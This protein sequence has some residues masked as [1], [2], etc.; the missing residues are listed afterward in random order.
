MTGNAR[1]YVLVL[2][3]TVTAA[4]DSLGPPTDDS[5]R[6]PVVQVNELVA[7]ELEGVGDTH[8]YVLRGGSGKARVRLD[9]HVGAGGAPVMVEVLDSASSVLIASNAPGPMAAPAETGWF[10]LSSMK[11]YL[12][13]VYAAASNGALAYGFRV[14]PLE[15]RVTIGDTVYGEMLP[16]SNVTFDSYA[17]AG[18]TGLEVVIFL[19]ATSGQD[20]QYTE[21]FVR[22]PT[23]DVNEWIGSTS[24]SGADSVLEASSTGRMILPDD[25][26][27]QIEIWGGGH[28]SAS[29]HGVGPYRF[30][31]Y[32]VDR[33][34]ETAPSRIEI[35][36]TIT[37]AIDAVADIDEFVFHGEAGTIVNVFFQI[38]TGLTGG[39]W[40]RLLGIGEPFQE[41][42]AHER[43]PALEDYRTGRVVLPTTGDHRVRI[44]GRDR[45][46]PR[47]DTGFYRFEVSLVDP[48]PESV[49]TE[50]AIGQRVD[51]ERLDRPG[52]IDEFVVSAAPGTEVIVLFE[53]EGLPDEH[54]LVLT[55]L[56][57]DSVIWTTL[58]G[59]PAEYDVRFAF[60]TPDP[61]A[62]RVNS[63]DPASGH[64]GRYSLQ[65]FP[66]DRAPESISPQIEVGTVVTGETIDPRGEV[67]EFTFQGLA[68]QEVMIF[69]R[70]LPGFEGGLL[71]NL[72]GSPRYLSVW[73]ECDEVI[74]CHTGNLL[75][76]LPYDGT[77]TIIVDADPGASHVGSGPYEFLVF[78]IDRAP[79]HVSPALVIGDTVR[80]EPIFPR[81]DIDEFHF[82]GMAGDELGIY[83]TG[84]T[85]NLSLTVWSL[86]TGDTVA[87]VSPDRDEQEWGNFDLPATGP[88]LVRVAA[89]GTPEEGECEFIYR[90]D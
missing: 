62:V 57:A 35:G 14:L 75:W 9:L 17:L 52:D 76:L 2:L 71:L 4:C 30:F 20:A 39:V 40:V 5:P 90:R 83:F 47:L 56:E 86:D 65:L 85:D 77:N 31:V 73:E 61:H 87:G 38:E 48:A 7:A 18:E 27:Y 64:T 1:C 12:I 24:T 46:F 23:Q 28:P 41:I 70:V 26:D 36:D 66:L 3:L 21:L 55:A 58:A 42:A 44:E 13:R 25:G 32:P 79:E 11:V 49:P 84:S 29:R 45:G 19:Q 80:G 72:A 8:T 6:Y 63:F 60:V 78:P 50:L 54:P 69:A 88:Y 37:E 10:A 74:A 51:G 89:H 82:D 34:P 22:S 16:S 53:A 67:D 15:S 68:G 33:D 59:L 43:L 81:G